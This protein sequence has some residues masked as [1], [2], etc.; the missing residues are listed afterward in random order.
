MVNPAKL[1][2]LKSMWATFKNNH[3]KFPYFI[4]AVAKEGLKEGNIIEIS[5]KTTDGR[6]L[7]SNICLTESDMEL[8]EELKRQAK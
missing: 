1:L 8:I 7:A 4:Q 6:E 5:I 2:K 3:P